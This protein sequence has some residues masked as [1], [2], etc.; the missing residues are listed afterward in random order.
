[1]MYGPRTTGFNVFGSFVSAIVWDCLSLVFLLTHQLF[2]LRGVSG[3]PV[4]TADGE[5]V[6][7]LSVSDLR[8][9][10]WARIQSVKYEQCTS[11]Q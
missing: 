9:G 4:V 3:A 7:N 10:A 11:L 2:C 1:M 8:C 6:A 5:M